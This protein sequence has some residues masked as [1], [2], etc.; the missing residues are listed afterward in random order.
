MQQREHARLFGP[1][2]RRAPFRP[3]GMV[4]RF[5]DALPAPWL[6]DRLRCLNRFPDPRHSRIPGTPFYFSPESAF[7]FAG[8]G[9]VRFFPLLPVVARCTP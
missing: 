5:A 1:L 6:R 8:I 4:T 9:K 3:S 7:G 2:S